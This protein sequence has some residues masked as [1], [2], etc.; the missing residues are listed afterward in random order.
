MNELEII[1]DVRV[2][3][4]TKLT[5]LRVTGTV[6]RGGWFRAYRPYGGALTS[7]DLVALWNGNS[8]GAAIVR[9]DGRCVTT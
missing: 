9:H 3:M 4:R 7:T 2:A 6:G 8:P 1:N 5:V